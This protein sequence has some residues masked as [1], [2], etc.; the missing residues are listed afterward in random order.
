MMDLLMKGMIALMIGAVLMIIFYVIPRDIV[1][2]QTAS[3]IATEMGCEVIGSARDLNSVKFL[4]CN[5][6]V[7]VIRVK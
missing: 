1:R 6:E 3:Q 4:D 5:G 2:S 7:K